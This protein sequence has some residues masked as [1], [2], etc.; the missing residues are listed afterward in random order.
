MPKN[1]MR[2]FSVCEQL[3]GSK[4]RFQADEQTQPIAVGRLRD[5]KLALALPRIQLCWRC[6]V[7][8]SDPAACEFTRRPHEIFQFSDAATQGKDF[9]NHHRLPDRKS[10]Q[11]FQS[12]PRFVVVWI[13]MNADE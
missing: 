6:A 2:V 5:R 10:A 4:F 13:K 7:V 12:F 3:L 8:M 1:H 9:L 11:R